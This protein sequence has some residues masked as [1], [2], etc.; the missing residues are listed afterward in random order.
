PA[1]LPLPDRRVGPAHANAAP[2]R[3]RPARPRQ[4]LADRDACDAKL[5]RRA[6]VREDEHAD[7]MPPRQ[8]ARAPD[9]ALPA[10]A[11]HA[12]ARAHRALV[13]RPAGSELDRPPRVCGFD[14]HNASLAEPAVVALADDRNDD[15]VDAHTWVGTHRN[16]DR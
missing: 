15:L 8:A 12:G 14:L 3:L 5:S 1:P 16:L 9:S 11:A 10:E 6:E 7:R 13:E 2:R 4:Q